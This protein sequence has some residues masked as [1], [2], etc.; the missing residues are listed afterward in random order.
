MWRV[1]APIKRSGSAGCSEKVS[2]R[3]VKNCQSWSSP[4]NHWSEIRLWLLGPETFYLGCSLLSAKFKCDSSGKCSCPEWWCWEGLC[5]PCAAITARAVMVSKCVLLIPSWITQDASHGSRKPKVCVCGFYVTHSHLSNSG[6]IYFYA[7]ERRQPHPIPSWLC[8][9][10]T[11]CFDFLWLSVAGKVSHWV[12]IRQPW[13]LVWV[14]D[15]PSSHQAATCV[16]IL[17]MALGG[18]CGILESSH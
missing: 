16:I 10:N 1:T 15:L 17:R 3:A 5:Q 6:D 18:E 12:S 11:Q 2:H 14:Y 7:L 4:L 13:P 9:N 8:L